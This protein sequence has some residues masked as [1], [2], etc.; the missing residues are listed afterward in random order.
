MHETRVRRITH[1][2]WNPEVLA[3]AVV[4]ALS[5][6]TGGG[7]QA[8]HGEEH[9]LREASPVVDMLS[10][11]STTTRRPSHTSQIRAHGPRGSEVDAG[12]GTRGRRNHAAR[13][14]RRG[15]DGHRTTLTSLG[16]RRQCSFVAPA[17]EQ[18]FS[19][20]WDDETLSKSAPHFRTHVPERP[21]NERVMP[22]RSF[23][24]AVLSGLSTYPPV[25]F[26]RVPRGSLPPE[27]YLSRRDLHFWHV[28]FWVV[29]PIVSSFGTMR[30]RDA[31]D[32]PVARPSRKKR[33][34]RGHGVVLAQSNALE[35]PRNRTPAG[36][37]KQQP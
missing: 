26:T 17:N 16:L 4:V 24:D 6:N 8:R 22:T 19:V 7:D 13:P 21:V 15:R 10:H 34:P 20:F 2:R 36:R 28:R 31:S 14:V 3:D 29:F 1:R 33:Y 23:W 35:Y 11:R 37:D 30:R 12:I 32:P 5:V 25:S 9:H 18:I 27:A